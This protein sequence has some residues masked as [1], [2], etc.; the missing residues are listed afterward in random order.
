MASRSGAQFY[1]E[2]SDNEEAAIYAVH[3]KPCLHASPSPE[4][5]TGLEHLALIREENPSN[6]ADP[7][8]V[9]HID[10]F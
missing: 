1:R 10:H 5:S 3:N 8:T 2:D 6:A 4:Y 7:K 9:A